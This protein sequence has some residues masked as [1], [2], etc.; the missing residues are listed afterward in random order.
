MSDREAICDIASLYTF[1]GSTSDSSSEVSDSSSR[2][3]PGVHGGSADSVLIGGPGVPGDQACMVE[4]ASSLH[5]LTT[6]TLGENERNCTKNDFFRYSPFFLQHFY[7]A[8]RIVK[9]SENILRSQILISITVGYSLVPLICPICESIQIEDES[10]FL[11]YCNKYSILRN[12][13]YRK[14][15]HIVPTF[16]Q[17]SS[18]QAIGELMTSSNHCINIQL[19]K[20]ISSCFDLRNIL[21]SNQTSVT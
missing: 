16:K 2:H 7:F 3:G 10:H 8:N 18:L 4:I 17:L 20:F 9:N 21:L 14:I 13:F 1:T 5:F 19:A 6:G 12:E 11:T 15:E